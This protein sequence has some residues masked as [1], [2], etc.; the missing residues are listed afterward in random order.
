[1][2]GAA[3][4]G[5]GAVRGQLCSSGERE[6]HG[7][8]ARAR[9]GRQGGTVAQRRGRG[10]QGSASGRAGGGRLVGAMAGA[11][12]LCPYSAW[13]EG[14]G[15]RRKKGKEGEKEKRIG[16]KKKE[17]GKRKMERER[18]LSAGFAAA[19]GHART[20]AFGR[21]ATSTQDERKGKGNTRTGIEFGCRNGGFIWAYF[22]DVTEI[23]QG[24]QRSTTASINCALRCTTLINNRL[25]EAVALCRRSRLNY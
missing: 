3:A 23:N 25:T 21:S 22:R 1:M 20:A 18:E 12:L 14:G 2:G 10:E 4:N 17:K 19:V 7:G 13:E 8:G 6:S 24:G 9:R 15:G 5:G 16:K 11:G